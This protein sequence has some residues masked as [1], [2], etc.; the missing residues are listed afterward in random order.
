M[1]D[2]TPFQWLTNPTNLNQAVVQFI[3]KP[4]P[5]DSENIDIDE[6]TGALNPSAITWNDPPYIIIG[7]QLCW[8]QGTCTAVWEWSA[9]GSISIYGIAIFTSDI[10]DWVVSIRMFDTPLVLESGQTRLEI[11][12]QLLIGVSSQSQ[13]QLVEATSST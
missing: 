7:D 2:T 8:A 3:T 5:P 6:L 9:W 1:A 12:F 11:P 10:D 13:T 4:V